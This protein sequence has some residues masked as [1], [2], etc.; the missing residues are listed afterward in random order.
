MA[1]YASDNTARAFNAGNFLLNPENCV[2][3]SEVVPDTTA[4]VTADGRK[5]VAAGTV[6]PKND[7]TAT[8]IVYEDTDITNGAAFAS[9]I[10]SGTVDVS[11][12]PV[13]IATAAKTALEAKGFAFI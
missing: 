1:F 8:G 10:K 7:A 13:E 3:K 5:I 11:K 12:L 6:F 9:V 2:R 4:S